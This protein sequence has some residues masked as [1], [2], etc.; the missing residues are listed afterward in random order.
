MV[1]KE[2]ILKIR[3]FLP[4]RFAYILQKRLEGKGFHYSY[5]HIMK[6]LDPK[7][8]SRMNLDILD[9]ASLYALECKRTALGI[10]KR[11]RKNK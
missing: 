7:D 10:A 3:E 8:E 1:D 5:S 6:V 11:T 4:K 2:T 9:E